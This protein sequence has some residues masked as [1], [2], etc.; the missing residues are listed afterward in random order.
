MSKWSD[1]GV[2]R[3]Y[4]INLDART[5]KWKFFQNQFKEF[6]FKIQRF[7]GR[8]GKNYVD[9]KHI[10][11]A[12]AMGCKMSHIEIFREA[13]AEG[14]E[15]IVVFEDDCYM[16][17]HEE[18][19]EQFLR[20]IPHNWSWFNVFKPIDEFPNVI[21][22]H[23]DYYSSNAVYNTHCYGID[24]RFMRKVIAAHNACPFPKSRLIH[25]DMLI[26]DI[27]TKE[28]IRCFS[29]KHPIHQ[30]TDIPSDNDWSWPGKR[31]ILR[32]LEDAKDWWNPLVIAKCATNT[33]MKEMETAPG[34]DFEV[35]SIESDFNPAG[36]YSHVLFVRN[37]WLP[38]QRYVNRFFQASRM[39]DC[40]VWS[41]ANRV[42]TDWYPTAESLSG[43]RWIQN[44]P[45][46]VSD[47]VVGFKSELAESGLVDVK[48]GESL[49]Q[50]A[51]K[52]KMPIVTDTFSF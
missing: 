14:Y 20:T 18:R 35:A 12:G 33:R 49:G 1:Y 51:L 46:F 41:P 9:D 2:N 43:Y 23:G 50:R 16:R 32:K 44:S 45:S 26:N 7:S 25:I 3:A 11:Y 22:D 28:N 36:S 10:D 4:C 48:L 30:N 47:D 17:G 21:Y 24:A 34:F 31:Q 6:P 19:F 5:D 27:A 52:L 39:Y 42:D 37:G 8:V 15:R 40:G 13:L 29:P 38:I